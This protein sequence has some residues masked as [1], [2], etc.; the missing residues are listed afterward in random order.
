MNLILFTKI[1]RGIIVM[2]KLLFYTIVINAILCTTLIAGEANGQVKSI[3]EIYLTLKLENAPIAE[4]FGII[5]QQ[6]NFTF[7]YFNSNLNKQKRVSVDGEFKSLGD[8]LRQISKQA[9][10]RFKRVNETIYVNSKK[11][12]TPRV[13]EQIEVVTFDRTITGKITD[14]NG[15]PIPG[16]N[17]LV[18]NTTIGAITDANGNYKIDLP[19]E[20]EVLLVSFIGY[21]TERIT[22][23]N[24][25]VVNIILVE[26]LQSLEEVVVIG[27]G[28]QKKSHV[29]GSIA[30]IDSNEL[31]AIP[32]TNTTATLAGRLPGLVVTNNSGE[33]GNDV[34]NVSIRGFGQALVIV[35]G[36]PREFQQ[37]DPNEIES[38]TILK[39]AAAAIYGAQSGNGVILVTTKRGGKN[40]KPQVNYSGNVTFQQPTFFPNV[41]D[42]ASYASYIQRAELLEGVPISD[43][44]YSD[45]DIAKFRAGTEPGFRGAD[46]Q[47]IVFKDWATT[48]Q[49]NVNVQGGSENVNYFISTG[50][51]NQQSLLES[52]A[53]VFERYNFGATVDASINDKL[54]VGL[55]LKYRLE[56]RD[57]PNNLPGDRSEY[58]RIFRYV[59]ISN[60]TVEENPD[61]LL[62]AVSPL[63]DNPVAYAD[64]EIGGFSKDN[65]RQ[66][67]LIFNAD[68]EL[69]IEG[70]V[71]KG[72][73]AYETFNRRRR[74]VK[75]PFTVYEHD[76]NT[77]TNTP[78]NFLNE[79]DVI[80]SNWEG[81]RLT[82]QFSLGYNQ[83][84]GEHT[85]SGTLLSEYR[86]SDIYFSSARRTDLISTSIPYLFSGGGTQ[87][88]FDDP[89]QDGRRSWLGRLNYN[90]KEK[91]LVEGLFRSDANI[92]FPQDTRWGNFYGLSLGWVLSREN[93]LNESSLFEFLKVRASYGRLGDDRTIDSRGSARFDYLTGFALNGGRGNQFVFGDQT[94]VSTLRSIG[95]ANPGITWTDINTYNFGLD[96]ILFGGKLGVELDVFYRERKGLLATRA[97]ATPDTFGAEFPL[98]NLE[99]RDNRGFELVLTHDNKIGDVNINLSGNVTWTREK[100]V[101]VEEREFDPN[102]PDDARL[103]RRTGEWVNRSFGYRTD[104]F[105]D[106]QEEI[107]NDGIK[108]PQFGEPVLGDI[109]YVDRNGDG[110]ID[111]RD[112]EVLGRGQTPEMFYGLNIGADYKG[113]DLSML[114]QG[115]TNFNVVVNGFEVA[116]NTSIGFIPF[117][118]IVDNAWD[119]DNPSAAKLPAP[120]T[121]GLNPHNSQPAD[122]YFRDGTYLRLK[123]FSLGYSLPKSVLEKVS[124]R[125]ARIYL[126]AY[127]ILTFSQNDLFEFDPEARA[128]DSVSTYPVQKSFSLGI[129]L[130]L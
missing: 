42:A 124:I 118:Y 18:E 60:P 21:N 115:A 39:D 110:I 77:G 86:Y 24:Q 34:A 96:A 2:S 58:E 49:H 104:G 119:P 59:L 67:N 12:G 99:D 88:N 83:S 74:S 98:E 45:E 33:P 97:A 27:Y 3:N 90:Y 130:G 40:T 120:Q 94:F 38:I 13:T 123:A 73:I 55:N 121:G 76:F 28:T 69:P 35:D 68:Y 128:N 8:I 78:T 63:S 41:A 112:L 111:F 19:E 64:Q 102:D 70:L 92:Q 52:G 6:T 14:S 95:L 106:T 54:N 127:N 93:F 43:L 89:G 107:D 91:Y 37:L 81:S 109:K 47:D 84:F 5:E 10:L 26:D 50:A 30:T 11:F 114:W 62:A 105:Y 53:G 32:S 17:I 20:A 16:A 126:A 4:A 65:R 1:L 22:I 61:G 29:T 46:W 51:L 66:F 72:K 113:F 23:G 71:A 116:P 75:K 7:T 85:I 80:V 48:Q 100:F 57:N 87:T 31:T 129:N 122:I 79:N 56:D 108:Y 36:V 103:N 9:D 117:Q 25:T 82:T 125:R 44:T 101:S 15:E